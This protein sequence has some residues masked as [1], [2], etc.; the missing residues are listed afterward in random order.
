MYSRI[1]VTINVI[2]FDISNFD[3]FLYIKKNVVRHMYDYV[4]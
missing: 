1:Q 2:N 3:K 4:S